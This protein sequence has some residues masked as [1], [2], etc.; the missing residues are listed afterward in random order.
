MDNDALLESFRRYLKIIKQL[1]AQTVNAYLCDLF[2]L[3]EAS[4]KPLAL[5]QSDEIIAF[6]SRFDNK[7]TLN[8]KLASINAFFDFC[9]KEELR[10]AKVRIPMAK[11]PKTLPKYLSHDR[12][13]FALSRIDRSKPIGLRDYA[14]I[15]FLYA[16]GARISEALSAKREDIVEGWLKIRYGK[17]EKERLVPL[18]PMALEALEAYLSKERFSSTHLWLNYQGKPLSRISAYKIVKKHLGVSPHVLR[19]S[20]A[21]ALIV[22]GADLRV[23]Q[24]LLGHASLE[25]TQI[26]TH[27]EHSTLKETIDRH[28]PLR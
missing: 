14:L 16:S 12:I 10:S 21:S 19:H 2:Q 27:I 15:L 18:A 28:H 5:L 7:R 8:R 22:G 4:K 25:T 1:S 17:G 26:Y 20:F 24:E 6:L 23:V 11:V 9:H 13:M 3:A